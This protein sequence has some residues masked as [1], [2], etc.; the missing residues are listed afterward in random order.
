M[1][2]AHYVSNASKPLISP[3]PPANIT[4]IM[5]SNALEARAFQDTLRNKAIHKA[6]TD[7]NTWRETQQTL[8]INGLITDITGQTPN[9]I[10]LARNLDKLDPRIDAWVTSI[11]T[12]LKATII[13]MVAQEPI[14]DHLISQANKILEN[15]WTKKQVQITAEIQSREHQLSIN[16]E[17]HLETR[18]KAIQEEADAQLR[19]F[20]MDL[21][22][23]T[24]DEI[25]Q[26]KNKSK[27]IIQLMKDEDDSQ[28]LS[29]A[30]QTPKA[31]KPSPLNISKPKKRKKK[32]TIL[33]LMTPPPSNKTPDAP[34]DM[35]TDTDSTPTTPIC[36]SSAP[37]LTPLPT[38]QAPEMV[39]T[40]LADP[41]TIPRWARTPSPDDKTPHAPSFTITNPEPPKPPSSELMAIMAAIAGMK[42][43][44]L[45]RIE[46]VNARINQT[47]GPENISDYMVWN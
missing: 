11:C 8:L 28:M 2:F 18:K 21:D 32:V 5:L 19:K 29:L 4:D 34:T 35:E 14:E 17:H 43:E 23:K 36:R 41:D 20:K 16:A 30:I 44:L 6:I 7:I 38:T 24:A 12:D 42:S 33:D 1:L 46:K 47:N 27:T 37:S 15:A 3:P 26:L 22:A 31:T 25:Q 39:S 40:R 13:K 45:T 9:P 10:T